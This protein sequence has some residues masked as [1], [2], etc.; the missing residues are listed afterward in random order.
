MIIVKA[1]FLRRNSFDA[2]LLLEK[3]GV[4]HTTVNAFCFSTQKT[5]SAKTLMTE[6][7][8]TH[9]WMRQ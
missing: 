2:E 5:L 4:L 9:F 8:F 6:I 7:G 1:E 3:A